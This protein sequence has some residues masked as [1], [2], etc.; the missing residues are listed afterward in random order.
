MNFQFDSK[1]LMKELQSAE[2]GLSNIFIK[3]FKSKIIVVDIK[4]KVGYIWNN[5]TKIYEP[6]VFEMLINDMSG[7]LEKAIEFIIDK[8]NEND[9]L[10]DKEK[11]NKRKFYNDVKNS[12]NRKT[13]LNNIYSFILSSYYD[14]ELS[15]KIDNN[16]DVIPIKNGKLIDLRTGIVRDRNDND[17][18]TYEK[19]YEYLGRD[20]QHT[21]HTDKFFDDICLGNKDKKEYLKLVMGSSITSYTKMKCF[22]IFYGP[23]GNNGK[24]LMMELQ[25]KTFNDLYVALPNDLIYADNIDKIRD[26]EFGTIHGKTIATSIEP[27][28]KYINDPVIKLLTGSD[29]INGRIRYGD[30]FTFTPKV[31]IFILLNNVLRIGQNDIMK[32]RTRVINFDAE[33]VQNPKEPQQKKVDL[34]LGTKFLN[35]WKNDYFT[36]IV[37]C[38][39][40]FLKSDKTLKAPK[41]IQDDTNEYFN[42]TDYIGCALRKRYTFTKN[43]K[44]KVLRSDITA[45]YENECLENSKPFNKTKLLEYLTDLCGEA[46]EIKG[47]YYFKGISE[48]VLNNNEED[49]QENEKLKEKDNEIITLKQQNENLMK[50]IEELEALLK[51]QQ[52]KPAIQETPKEEIISEDLDDF[53]NAFKNPKS[54]VKATKKV[55]KSIKKTK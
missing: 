1:F 29:S 11:A 12:I 53:M 19:D 35:E 5:T 10:D 6:L 23:K 27:N 50:R 21:K 3:Y 4:K 44:D 26:T 34:E 46:K 38:A 33:F 7:L 9:F 25:Q 28:H 52:E 41:I 22:F 16:D 45:Y 54:D 40:D 20:A 17:Y 48:I 51:A 8:I 14:N 2:R 37:N 42:K 15:K 31:K 43:I 18:F 55:S 36:Y 32:N 47:Y 49:E 13:T 39:I 24:S 30:A